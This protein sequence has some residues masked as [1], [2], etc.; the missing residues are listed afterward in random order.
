MPREYRGF[1][2][3]KGWNFEAD[4]LGKGVGIGAQERRQAGD[5]LRANFSDIFLGRVFVEL[6]LRQGDVG[7]EGDDRPELAA[8]RLFGR[9]L[10]ERLSG[11]RQIENANIQEKT[12]VAGSASPKRTADTIFRIRFRKDAADCSS[13]G[14]IL[15]SGAGSAVTI[16][17]KKLQQS[18]AEE[19]RQVTGLRRRQVGVSI[20]E[21]QRRFLPGGCGHRCGRRSIRRS[22][23]RRG[24]RCWGSGANRSSGRRGDRSAGRSDDWCG[25]GSCNGFSRGSSD[26][27]GGRSCNG[28]GRRSGDRSG[29]GSGSGDHG[30]QLKIGHDNWN[31]W[32]GRFRGLLLRKA[33][34]NSDRSSQNKK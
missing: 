14:W 30:V 9:Q 32:Q 6:V 31:R 15:T 33:P 28:C 24:D 17:L 1:G 25:G 2:R 4:L 10:I 8:A 13:A 27:N 7:V 29:R 34:G 22:G 26:R 12:G 21:G 18:L 5:N 23:R 3:Q 19:I 16:F 11:T 20:D